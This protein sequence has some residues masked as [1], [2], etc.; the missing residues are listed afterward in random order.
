MLDGQI[1]VGCLPLHPGSSKETALNHQSCTQRVWTL[2]AGLDW[3]AV[4]LSH[5]ASV[6][7]WRTASASAS[8][9]PLSAEWAVRRENVVLIYCHH[10]RMQ[11]APESG[12]DVAFVHSREIVFVKDIKRK[13]KKTPLFYPRVGKS[14][15]S[16]ARSFQPLNRYLIFIPAKP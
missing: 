15:A 11:L 10:T 14:Y 7:L 9:P 1:L 3:T 5:R 8:R 4:R 13:K 2:G 16:Q 12:E 6:G